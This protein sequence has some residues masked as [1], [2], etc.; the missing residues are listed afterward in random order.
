MVSVEDDEECTRHV[1]REQDP[2]RYWCGRPVLAWNWSFENAEHA[3]E[4]G[5][6]QGR[7]LACPECSERIAKAL[8]HEEEI[9]Q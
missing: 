3:A 8:R 9:A 1:R 6:S 5:A 2:G 4:N 7:L